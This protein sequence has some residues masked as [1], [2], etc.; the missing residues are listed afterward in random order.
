M[1]EAIPKRPTIPEAYI[2]VVKTDIRDSG[3]AV[4]FEFKFAA[5]VDPN[6]MSGFWN[7]MGSTVQKIMLEKLHEKGW[8][9]A[10]GLVPLVLFSNTG[11]PSP[12]GK[13][14]TVTCRKKGPIPSPTL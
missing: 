14:W 13:T 3:N 1:S 12:D 7:E 6:K 9:S 5:A 10:N 8:V 11:T 2:E 4:E